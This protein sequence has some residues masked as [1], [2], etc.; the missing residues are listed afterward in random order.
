MIKLIV[1]IIGLLVLILLLSSCNKDNQSNKQIVN[2]DVIIADDTTEIADAITVEYDI[3]DLKEFFGSDSDVQIGY[4]TFLNSLSMREVNDKYPIEILRSSKYTIY[5]IKEGG[6]FFV[7]WIR[8]FDPDTYYSYSFEESEKLKN[9]ISCDMDNYSVYFTTYITSL[10]KAADFIHIKEKISTARDVALIA[11]SME[12]AFDMSSCIS[13]YTILE[14]N[15]IMEVR[16]HNIDPNQELS[17]AVVQE[18]TIVKREDSCSNF[19]DVLDKDLPKEV[20]KLPH[21]IKYE[22]RNSF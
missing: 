21:R 11:P 14:N 7:F 22:F 20:R 4:S 6:Y 13:S 2:K 9:E 16:Y 15:M 12:F 3:K 8:T 10:S 19:S 1:K 5:K 17:E 18:K